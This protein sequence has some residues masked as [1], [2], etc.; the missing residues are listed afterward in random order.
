MNTYISLLR[1]INVSGQKKI[2]MAD[3]KAHYKSLGF[4]EVQT[5]IQSGNVLFNTTLKDEAAMAKKILNK[6]KKEYRFEVPI[7]ITSQK[8]LKKV[9][10][11][12]PFL[13]NT[14]SEVDIK[15]LYVTFLAEPA[16]QALIKALRSHQ[17]P[18]DDFMLDK[19]TIYIHCPGGY[20]RTKLN[21][22]FFERKLKVQCTTRNWK[23]V[24][25][26]MNLNGN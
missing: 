23:T 1:G 20:G 12:N 21:N 26:L 5:Y 16:D 4:T 17:D 7:L 15:Y 2:N 10:N 3:L 18:T 9:I 11:K 14:N 24:N 13:K 22:N 25:K 8:A 6:I 19:Q